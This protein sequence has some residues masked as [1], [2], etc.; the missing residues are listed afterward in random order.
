MHTLISSAA[1]IH[2]PTYGTSSPTANSTASSPGP[3]QT[4]GRLPRLP[5]AAVPP[6]H[7]GTYHITVPHTTSPAARPQA[8]DPRSL[9]KTQRGSIDFAN[10]AWYKGIT[11]I[12]T[13]S[14]TSGSLW[15]SL[16]VPHKRRTFSQALTSNVVSRDSPLVPSISSIP[17]EHGIN[18][19]QSS[20]SRTRIRIRP[21]HQPQSTEYYEGDYD[22]E[23]PPSRESTSYDEEEEDDWEDDD[24]A[25]SDE[26]LEPSDSASSPARPHRSESRHP[27]E[28]LQRHVLAHRP[29]SRHRGS[30]PPADSLDHEYDYYGRG[31][32]YAP[33]G[34]GY[35]GRG[36]P[37]GGYPQSHAGAG[38]YGYESRVVP[39]G[40][41]GGGNNPFA[42]AQQTG[43]NY[44]N[45]DHWGRQNEMMP[46]GHGGHGNYFAP[47][48]QMPGHLQQYH[49][50]A[51]P[52]PPTEIAPPKTP[53]PPEPPKRGP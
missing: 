29:S 2:L 32:A 18:I 41:Y 42:P 30:R 38:A 45:N 46:Y 50:Q 5:K 33:P 27:R 11:C 25:D 20:T 3:V 6:G 36:H 39:Y 28:P 40:P 31:G 17:S 47:G 21:G 34:A 10:A 4:A 9:P 51:P 16:D 49:W 1:Y 43:G 15:P 13:H 7:D 23:E 19:Q 26:E 48:Y 14:L 44:F 53:S 35:Y 12:N 37:P 22:D 8:A 52:P 24:L